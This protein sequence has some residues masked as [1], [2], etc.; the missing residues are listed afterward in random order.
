MI[1]PSN[2]LMSL[3][4]DPFD[5]FFMNRSRHNILRKAQNSLALRVL[6]VLLT[7]LL[8][9][10]HNL[11]GLKDGKVT[12]SAGLYTRSLSFFLSLFLFL[13]LSL[14]GTFEILRTD[15]AC[16]LPHASLSENLRKQDRYK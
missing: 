9:L 13:S 10:N 3:K 14:Y 4:L 7:L 1:L 5:S 16:G 11:S 8:G 15:T 2:L 12:C 6:H